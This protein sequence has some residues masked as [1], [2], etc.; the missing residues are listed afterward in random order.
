MKYFAEIFENKVINVLVSE[1]DIEGLIEYSV[2]G[3]FRANPAVIGGEYDSTNDVFILPK[4]YNSWVLNSS[5]FKWES[6][7]GDAPSDGV[8]RWNEEEDSWLKL[9]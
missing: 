3:S 7:I 2:D 8:Y 6:P 1:T 9:S 4:P 5:T